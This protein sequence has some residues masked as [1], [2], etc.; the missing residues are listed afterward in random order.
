MWEIP[1][2]DTVIKLDSRRR[3]VFPLPFKPG[4]VLA[5]VGQSSDGIT[6]RIV[7]PADVPLI[8]TRIQQGFTML[9]T[10]PATAEQIVSAI[11]ADRNSR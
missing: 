5:Q 11:R 2:V 8:R 10:A 3:G 1:T 9:K 6:F 7:K 4:D